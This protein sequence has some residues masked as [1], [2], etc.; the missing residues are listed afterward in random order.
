MFACE[1]EEEEKKNADQT[2]LH[3]IKC[4]VNPSQDNW[5]SFEKS[6]PKLTQTYDLIKCNCSSSTIHL[7]EKKTLQSWLHCSGHYLSHQ[8]IKGTER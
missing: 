6:H 4:L 3:F 8:L 7:C 5:I 2:C 1:K